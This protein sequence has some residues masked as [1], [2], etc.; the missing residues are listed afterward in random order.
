MAAMETGDGERYIDPIIRLYM[1]DVDR[2]LIRENLKL[3]VKERFEK[4]M[5]LQLFAEKIRGSASKSV[6]KK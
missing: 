6:K 1:K 4:H 5:S 2:T 3:S